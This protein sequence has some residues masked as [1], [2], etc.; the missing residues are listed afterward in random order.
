[1]DNCCGGGCCGEEREESL[2]V[3]IPIKK[4]ITESPRVK[5]YL[6]DANLN[7]SPG[8]FI[9][10]WIPG[11]GERPVAIYEE[12]G[13]FRISVANIGKVSGELHKFKAGD[14]VGIRGPYGTSFTL[15]RAKG[16]L[17]MVA[18]GYGIVPL[19]YLAIEA[20]KRGYN[21]T[22]LNGART[23]KEALYQDFLKKKKIKML[24]STDDGSQ[25]KKGY[26]HQLLL[27]YLSKNR[28]PKML[29][30]CGPEIM[31]YNVA[32]VCWAKKIPLQ[33]SVERYMKCGIGVCGSC[34]VD[35][36]GWRMC[37]E[38]PIVSGEDLKKITEF[39]KYH[40]S[41]SGMPHNF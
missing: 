21:P 32:K 1:M 37:M 6:F 22:I 28:K 38:G 9:M 16:D 26:V 34:S 36:T 31:E 18:G 41:A 15:P 3:L 23:A 10:L 7:A 33:V 19:A 40:R 27:E 24:I 8:Q 12:E 5:S 30:T 20:Q 17:V 39:G 14:R 35:P 2:P 4:V 11:V 13:S 29:Y 25:G